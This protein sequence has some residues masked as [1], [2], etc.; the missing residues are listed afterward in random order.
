ME[1]S[2]DAETIETMTH[3]PMGSPWAAHGQPMDPMGAGMTCV[4]GE[5]SP[6]TDL[7]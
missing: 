2:G 5:A 6:A 7:T 1:V 3:G 4:A